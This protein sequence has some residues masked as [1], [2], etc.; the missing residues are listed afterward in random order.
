MNLYI[1]NPKGL[2]FAIIIINFPVC[3]YSRAFK[4]LFL[5][6]PIYSDH[7][8]KLKWRVESGLSRMWLWSKHTFALNSKEISI[9]KHFIYNTTLPW[10]KSHRKTFIFCIDPMGAPLLQF[11]TVFHRIIP[12]LVRGHTVWLIRHTTD[13]K[14]IG[15]GWVWQWKLLKFDQKKVFNANRN[16][17]S[18]WTHAIISS[19][20]PSDKTRSIFVFISSIIIYL[21]YL[22]VWIKSIF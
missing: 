15:R 1:S 8:I 7:K 13:R 3:Y 19:G 9:R 20:K 12:L 17:T 18:N 2:Y 6:I 5:F 4:S 10:S 22:P 16:W 11:K 21:V 14:V